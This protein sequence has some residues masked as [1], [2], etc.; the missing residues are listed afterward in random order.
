M[1]YHIGKIIYMKICL[2]DD[3]FSLSDSFQVVDSDLQKFCVVT[4]ANYIF[5]L[6]V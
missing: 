5:V 1:M 6:D 3:C 4:E 2:C